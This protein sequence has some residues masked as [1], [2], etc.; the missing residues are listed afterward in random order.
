MN[1]PSALIH[2]RH[3][4]FPSSDDE[5]P[6]PQFR[7]GI[8]RHER[9]GG[10]LPCIE[11]RSEG[12]LRLVRLRANAVHDFR[13]REVLADDSGGHDERLVLAPATPRCRTEQSVRLSDHSPGILQPF[14]P[15]HCIRTPA[16]HDEG[17]SP[18]QSI[19]QHFCRHEDWSS[20]ECVPCE[21]T[22]GGSGVGG[23]R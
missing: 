7:K 18:P 11:P 10:P 14:F 4:V 1:H 19:L 21:T 8:G 17:L 22:R 20:F 13:D 2:A 15:R 5:R 6:C 9:L 3:T 23:G 12:V 16:V